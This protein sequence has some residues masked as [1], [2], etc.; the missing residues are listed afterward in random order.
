MP[1][2]NPPARARRYSAV[3]PSRQDTRGF[4]KNTLGRS[5]GERP[6]KKWASNT[7]HSQSGSQK[8]KGLL[9]ASKFEE[10]WRGP[11]SREHPSNA[12]TAA[13]PD[14]CK[15]GTKEKPD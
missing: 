11:T 14:P 8:E 6:E 9:N 12:R 7:A 5:I 2:R 13:L 10:A 1:T 15:R 3:Q 4:R